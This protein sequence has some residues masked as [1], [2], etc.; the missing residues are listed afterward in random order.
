MF[1]KNQETRTQKKEKETRYKKQKSTK[2][3]IK[4]TPL[5]LVLYG[6]GWGSL[7]PQDLYDFHAFRMKTLRFYLTKLPLSTIYRKPVKW[8]S[9]VFNF[10]SPIFHF[11]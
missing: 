8:Y 10:Q 9:G 5:V 4:N 11:Q 7:Y 2:R 3:E 6:K 1:K